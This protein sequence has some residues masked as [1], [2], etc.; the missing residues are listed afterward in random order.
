MIFF[1]SA[2]SVLFHWGVMQ[3]VIRKLAWVMQVTMRT[4]AAESFNVAGNIFLGG[5]CCFCDPFID[6]TMYKKY[7][8][9]YTYIACPSRASWPLRRS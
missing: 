5:V 8:I 7:V 4:T 2:M 9:T 6:L 3:Y 1:G